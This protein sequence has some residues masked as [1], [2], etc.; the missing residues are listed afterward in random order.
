VPQ[1]LL[2]TLC[3]RVPVVATTVGKDARA[4]AF[5]AALDKDPHVGSRCVLA[6]ECWSLH[7]SMRL[8]SISARCTRLTARA[9]RPA[10][11][12]MVPCS[13]DCTSYYELEAAGWLAGYGW[14]WGR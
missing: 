8:P 4:Q 5:L 13:I 12:A 9:C 14:G 6:T 1:A 10:L 11:S 3:H 2:P 7:R